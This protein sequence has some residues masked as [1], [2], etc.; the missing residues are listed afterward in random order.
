MNDNTSNISAETIEPTPL[1]PTKKKWMMAQYKRL[2]SL[3]PNGKH[4]NQKGT[5]GAFGKC[6]RSRAK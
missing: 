5:K 6:K 3:V 1:T 4:K 2:I